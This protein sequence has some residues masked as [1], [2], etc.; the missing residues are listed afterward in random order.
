MSI[1]N[2]LR[3]KVA[4]R[5]KRSKMPVFVRQDF[6]DLAGYDQ[7]G[8]ALKELVGRGLLIKL[9]YGAYAR[10]KKSSISG[11]LVPEKPLSDLTKILLKKL[12]IQAAPSL[13]QRA[14][15][16]GQ[17][18]QVPAGR[19]IGVNR[20]INRQVGYNGKYISFEKVA[21]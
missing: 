1:S 7:V 2:T 20:R 6:K 12:G 3:G 15:N 19:V 10:A 21:S 4:Y 8:R 17:S 13:A 16:A 11:N 18:T 9:G 14:Y 5:I